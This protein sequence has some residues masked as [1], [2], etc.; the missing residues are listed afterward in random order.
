MS[1]G[2][3]I[4]KKIIRVAEDTLISEL[5]RADKAHKWIEYSRAIKMKTNNDKNTI[6]LIVITCEFLKIEKNKLVEKSKEWQNSLIKF[7]RSI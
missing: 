3:V 4:E 2:V 7:Y 1:K 6:I 5:R